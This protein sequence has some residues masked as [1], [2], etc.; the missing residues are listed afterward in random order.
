MIRVNNR[1]IIRKL[2]GVQFRSQKTR[3]FL[4]MIAVL[5]ST[6]MLTTVCNLGITYYS[7]LTDQNISI[8]GSDYDAMLTGPS[9]AQ[10]AAAKKMP[11]VSAAGIIVG[12][13]TLTQFGEIPLTTSLA[14][15]D[16]T[17]WEIQLKPAFESLVGAYPEAKN[18]LLLSKT[19]L[20][21]MGITKP[22]VGMVL[23]LEFAAYD[24]IK[25]EQFIL[26]GYF[27]DYSNKNRG[28]ISRDFQEIYGTA[29]D[30]LERGRLYLNFNT[31]FINEKKAKKM[32]DQLQLKKN[33]RLH[34][35]T[36][37]GALLLRMGAAVLFL[38]FLI[39]LTAYLLIH[40]ILLISINKEIRFYGLLKTVGTT[41]KQIRQIVYRQV[42]IVTAIGITLGLFL[43]GVSSQKIV[44][45]ILTA[46]SIYN[47][48][49]AMNFHF[50]IYLV[51]AIF[52][53]LTIFSSSLKPAKI[54]SLISP[55]EALNHEGSL[56]SGK[57][58][59]RKNG[60]KIYFMAWTNI[61][62]YK[63]QTLLV[64][65]SLFLGITSFTTVA[66][67][68]SANEADKILT[69]LNITDM[70]L[71]NK[72][73]GSDEQVQQFSQKTIAEI[74]RIDGVASVYP[75]TAVTLPMT[76][77]QIFTDYYKQAFDVFYHYDLETGMEEMEKQPANFNMTFIGLDIEH[78]DKLASEQQFTIDREAFL[79]G[80][81]GI[82]TSIGLMTDSLKDTISQKISYPAF[83]STKQ[84]T[85]SAV[86]EFLPRAQYSEFYPDMVV[87]NVF[88][89]KLMSSNAFAE[90]EKVDGAVPFVDHLEITYKETY[91]R[92]ADQAILHLI[93][94]N[95]FIDYESKINRYDNMKQ[96]E[97][98]LTIVG[99]SIAVILALLGLMN[100][101]NLMVTS[102]NS[103]LKEIAIL[104]SV[105]MT[106]RQLQKM[107]LLEGLMYSGFSLFLTST[108]G[109]AISYLI[110]TT[111]NEYQVPFSFP[112]LL[113]IV[114]YTA[115]ILICV[116]TPLLALK[117]VQ[118]TSVIEQLRQAQ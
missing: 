24:G 17:N 83:G 74:E 8:N 64:F 16:E 92:K 75:I 53:L 117:Y 72:T 95:N 15:S 32:E 85:N 47:I 86:I 98:Q 1:P 78:L 29:S 39:T 105:G 113:I 37:R 76:K 108:V 101:V 89:K 34:I 62:R 55:I 82:L 44:P 70:V 33:Q 36:E 93:R 106:K 81:I 63:K 51:A 79:A 20:K 19:A 49:I 40:N 50:S 56:S 3:N 109:T 73:S 38:V 7:S 97:I 104:Q 5:L 35:D 31:P 11:E 88:L 110:F 90:Q 107:L 22:Q 77:Q 84:I 27:N 28:F 25:N 80:E 6:F 46:V 99:G 60:S 66:T 10:V 43:S 87:S 57:M 94:N 103:R 111:L 115:A 4:L 116:S 18:E 23:D 48:P 68:T 52:V 45:H 9:E 14:W 58:K 69:A 100:Y 54:A 102:I 13:V 91:D 59:I 41:K 96:S 71:T 67:L 112:W 2:A 118:R 30:D 114:I 12:C 21:K 42:L 26:S 61:F 65:L